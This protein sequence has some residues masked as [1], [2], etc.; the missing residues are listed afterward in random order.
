M[1][2][3]V[4]SEE[5]IRER[6]YSIWE[7][8]GRPEGKSVEHWLQAKAELEAESLAK[9][10]SR[11]FEYYSRLYRFEEWQRSVQPRPRISLPPQVTM[12]GRIARDRRPAAA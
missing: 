3:A 4:V 11:T 2:V 6:S 7:R 8:Q 1:E 5:A 12:A 9:Q 10:K